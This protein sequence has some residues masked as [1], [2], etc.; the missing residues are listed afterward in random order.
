MKW[1]LYFHLYKRF[2]IKKKGY[3][4]KTPI[5]LK[6]VIYY[7]ESGKYTYFFYLKHT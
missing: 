4:N 7:N 6:N 2:L 5:A 3:G 1:H